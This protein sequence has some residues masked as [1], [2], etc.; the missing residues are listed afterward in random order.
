MNKV[1]M[2]RIKLTLARIAVL[3]LF[4]IAML[5][6]GILAYKTTGICLFCDK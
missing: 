4:L 6:F 5:M 3:A 2:E 1:D